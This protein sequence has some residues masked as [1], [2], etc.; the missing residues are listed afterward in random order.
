MRE[1][2]VAV[3]QTEANADQAAQALEAHGIA[4]SMIRRYNRDDVVIPHGGS[5]TAGERVGMAPRHETSGGFWSWLFGETDETRSYGPDYDRDYASYRGAVESGQTVLGVLVEQPDA[6]RVLSL[7]AEQ[8]P[9]ELENMGTEHGAAAAAETRTGTQPS[10]TRNQ[11]GGTVQREEVIPLA[12]ENVEIGKRKVNQGT[13]RVHRYVVE[14][15]V[16]EQVRLRDEH[17]EVERRKPTQQRPDGTAFQERTV[18]VHE[19]RE[20]PD[21]TRTAHVGEEVVVRKETTER[22]ETVRTTRRKEEVAVNRGTG[23]KRGK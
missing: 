11:I 6:E 18:E 14:Q 4:G 13:T 19:T 1:M 2:L 22:P 20:E 23:S 15:P 5:H 10:L 12:E 16:E 7:L 3:F 17:V 8:M 9:V 21:V